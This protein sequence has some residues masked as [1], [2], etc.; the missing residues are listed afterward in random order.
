M[1]HHMPIVTSSTRRKTSAVRMLAAWVS[2][3]LQQP[4]S[5]GDRATKQRC[6]QYSPVQ[7]KRT[8]VG[9]A[10]M[11]LSSCFLV[12]I[13]VHTVR[14]AVQV[15]YLKSDRGRGEADGGGGG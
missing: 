5:T 13:L 11:P 15:A 9:Q 6:R 3:L 4:G 2:R 12:R 14:V 7:G 1:A 8:L 10:T